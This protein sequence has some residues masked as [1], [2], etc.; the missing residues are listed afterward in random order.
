MKKLIKSIIFLVIGFALFITVQDVLTPNN[1]YA[2]T[3]IINGL[4]ALEDNTVD[5]VFLGASHM[6]NGM[7]PM[8]IYEETKICGY[9]LGTSGQPIDISYYLLKYFL[10]TQ[11][12]S[13]VFFDVSGMYLDEST[14]N[15]NG[16]RR[17]VIDN[18]KLDRV[19]LEMAQVYDSM[20]DNDGALSVIFPILKYHERWSELTDNDFKEFPI[21]P[22]YLAGEVM[23]EIVVPAGLSIA[24]LNWALD[25]IT[26]QDKGST[27]YYNG[28]SVV[29]KEVAT[30]T[31]DPSITDFAKEYLM[32]MDQLCR[33][34][35]IALVLVKIPALQYPQLYSASWTT[36]KSEQMKQL[37]KELQVP[38]ID[39]MYDY[40]IIDYSTDTM[41]GGMHLNFRG[42]EKISETLGVLLLDMFQCQPNPNSTYDAMLADYQK[43]RE[44][45]LLQ[46]ETNFANYINKLVQYSG[47]WSIFISVCNEHMLSATDEVN[48][49]LSENFGLQFIGGYPSKNSYVAL[50]D[51]GNLVHEE[52]SNRRINRNME[53]S[54]R[55]VSI[56]SSGWNAKPNVSIRI[57]GKEYSTGG[58]GLNVVVYDNESGLVIDSV[59]FDTCLERKTATRN[60]TFIDTLLRAYESTVCFD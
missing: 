6:S 23:S 28:Y 10:K 3:R 31:Y 32:K 13:V 36:V 39:F 14:T 33:E 50:I 16:Y 20:P 41:D 17:F 40:D 29:E 35:D 21:V 26:T 49:V 45:V 52:T 15:Y 4:E 1:Q 24:N 34:N 59:T 56:C 38:Y 8:K 48:M 5:A 44:I 9:N 42:A 58:R 46:S 22:H 7:S 55:Q 51:Q 11:H 60:W 27:T 12:P 54:G 53:V 43:I 30:S 47:D 25:E 2:T 57:G 19:K 18:L 37:G